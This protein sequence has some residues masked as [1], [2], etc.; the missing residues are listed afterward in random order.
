MGTLR[1]VRH[2]QAS[3]GAANYDVLSPT[4][5][6]Q[7]AAL[8]RAW[9]TG[10]AAVDAIYTGPMQRQ[11]DTATH[12]LAAAAAAGWPLPTPVV[13]DE[14]A[15]Y[16]AFELLGRCLPQVVRD[17]P[18]LAGL[19]TGGRVDPALA[20]RA[21]WKVVD[22]WTQ[23]TLDTGA[24]ETFAQFV[25]RVE[26]AVDRMIAPGAGGGRVVVAV[27]S[28]GPIGVAA[29]LA[30]GLDARATVNLWRLVRNGSVS[31][32]LWRHRGAGRELS[33]LGWNH[34][35]HLADELVTYR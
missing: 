15:E 28:G 33:L 23:G 35:D 1:L 18:A 30:L 25:A 27:T 17:E 32:L 13:L 7:A 14:L 8:G 22:A 34:V 24:L 20:D 21:L 5:V 31:E 26:R 6:A 29:R 16:P 2:G 11:R 3:Y 4:G 12:A 10:R 19:V 9:A